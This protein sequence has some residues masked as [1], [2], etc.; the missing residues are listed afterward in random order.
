[1]SNREYRYRR[2]DA[3]NFMI[4]RQAERGAARWFIE[5]YYSII[6]SLIRA[7]LSKGIEGET[8]RELLELISRAEMRLLMAIC[9][10]EI[11]MCSSEQRTPQ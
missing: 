8:S 9:G 11:A 4:E 3:R 6:D 10:G 2:S 7:P 5:S 1:M